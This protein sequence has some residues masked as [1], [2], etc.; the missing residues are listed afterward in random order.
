MSN[1]HSAFS[2]QKSQA[3]QRSDAVWD[4]IIVGQGLAGTALAWCLH[5][6][7]QRVLLLDDQPVVTS[8][9]TAAGLITPITGQRMTVSDTY[10]ETYAAAVR[11]YRTCEADTGQLFFHVRPAIRLLR[12]DAERQTWQSRYAQPAV[13]MHTVAHQPQPLLDADVA[14]TS[15]GGFAMPQAAQLDVPAY[16]AASRGVLPNMQIAV[17]WA[18]D[19]TF[20]TDCVRVKTLRSRLLI[21]CE[22][23]AAA[24][25][26]YLSWLPFKAAKGDVLTVR[27]ER[28]LPTVTL[29]RGIWIAPTADAHVY[30]VGASY[31]WDT[32]DQVPNASARGEIE[33]K[34]QEF[35]RVPY[36][37]IAHQAAVRPIL[38][39]IKPAMGLH[40]RQPR[41]G[42]FNG[43]G[44][45]G[46]LLAPWFAQRFTQ[47][48]LHGAPLPDGA[49]SSA[50]AAAAKVV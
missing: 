33:A 18:R 45:K 21:S 14:D 23:F 26:P 7:G 48:L 37:V 1:A 41:L 28:P 39:D 47:F 11:F 44:S 30:R 24:R 38:V 13:L 3:A 20:D 8:S 19:V 50:T 16:L 35:I 22:G 10:A 49:L 46:S 17:D 5:Q 31:D 43:L 27:F 42:Y 34:L 12:S 32:L 29:H 9:K 15:G 25:N 40:P 36:S 4:A 6:A 2:R